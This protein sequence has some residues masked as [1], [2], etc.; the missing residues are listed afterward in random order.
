MKLVFDTHQNALGHFVCL[1]DAGFG[2]HDDEFISAIASEQ[3][4]LTQIVLEKLGKFIEQIIAGRVSIQL[5]NLFEVV[6]IKHDHRQVALVAHCE[7]E[8]A[9]AQ[10]KHMPAVVDFGYRIGDRQA[11]VFGEQVC[12]IECDGDIRRQHFQ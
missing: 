4:G 6:Q 12:V 8:L 11:L 1:S 3:I 7:V 9:L 5:I 10:F 2:Q